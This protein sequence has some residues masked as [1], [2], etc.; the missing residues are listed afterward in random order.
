MGSS[1]GGDSSGLSALIAQRGAATPMPGLPVAGKD[2]T[3]GDPHEYGTFQNFLPDIQ[4]EGPNPSATGLRPEMF[5]YK[6]PQGVVDP[7][8]QSL[9]NELA[10]LKAQGQGQPAAAPAGNPQWAML[11]AQM[12]PQDIQI[13]QRSVSPAEFQAFMSS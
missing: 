1:G 8:I 11:R 6:K 12:S 3:I 5:E 7:E 9:R 4:A 10:S 13:F 2:S